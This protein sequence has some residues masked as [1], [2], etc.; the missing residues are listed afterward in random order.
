MSAQRV[1]RD[2]MDLDPQGAYD[3]TVPWPDAPRRI[4]RATE[5]VYRSDKWERPKVHDYYH[6]FSSAV[7]VV[8]DAT[9]PLC[10]HRAFGTAGRAARPVRKVARLGDVLELE[11]EYPDGRRV[12]R[13]LE[14]GRRL[15]ASPE[16]CG[17]RRQGR[18][19]LYLLD[20]AGVIVLRG[21]E[22]EIRPEGI[23]G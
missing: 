9:H 17:V 8:V 19:A 16:L 6:P 14:R 1:Y 23:T 3:R 13:R 20:P 10:P 12:R 4:G 21:G 18:D 2:F 15:G 11:L 5:I 7:D 22:L